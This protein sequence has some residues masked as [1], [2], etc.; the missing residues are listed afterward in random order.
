MDKNGFLL[1]P[2]FI[3]STGV[4][5][6]EKKEPVSPQGNTEQKIATRIFRNF[7]KWRDNRNMSFA[8]FRGRTCLEFWDDC[9][10]R[11]NNYK[12]KP[13]WKDDWQANISDITTHAKLM[14]IVAQSTVNRYKPVFSP[15][16]GR[17]FVSELRSQILQDIYDF[18]E[19]GSGSGT[20]NG[21]L[22][23]LLITLNTAKF[24]TTIGFEG[25]KKTSLYE[26][27]DS[28]II[29]LED[30]YPSDM[31]KFANDQVRCIWRSIISEDE[32]DENFSAWH[33]YDKVAIRVKAGDSQ[34]TTFFNISN[35]IQDKQI[36]LLRYFDKLNDEFYITA[37]GVLITK[38]DST[39]SARRKD[40]ELGFWGTLFEPY[41]QFTFGRSLPDLMKDNQDGID[42]LFNAMYDKELLAVMRPMMVGGVN[43]I[44]DDYNY[45]GRMV[46]VND[47]TQVKEYP[48]APPDLNSFRILK[49]L[50]DRQHFV[51][52]DQVSQG[53]SMGKKTATEVERA[54]EAAKRLSSILGTFVKHGLVQKARLRTGIILQYLIKSPKFRQ[55]VSENVK[56]FE[57]GKAGARTIRIKPKG[58]LAPT[59]GMGFSPRLA[60]EVGIMRGGARGNE[61]IE[62]TP[63]QIADFEYKIDVKAPSSIEMSPALKRAFDI[64]FSQT[65]FARPDV[66][67]QNAVAKDYAEAMGKDYEE[68]RVKEGEQPI[69]PEEGAG[70]APPQVPSLQGMLP[71]TQGIQ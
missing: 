67:D 32:F 63:E 71:Q 10:Q 60:A 26:G 18:T 59:T 54:Q 38:P 24:G 37:N 62:M 53:V 58:Q 61:I 22:D 55:F 56:L 27:I 66:Y 15:R 20:R 50:Q 4:Q 35:E 48:L 43:Q 28:Q 11:F 3:M 33:Q 57:T 45:P 47:V 64:Q 23:N 17:D 52:V 41:G 1:K 49:E 7:L 30:Y 46:N 9:E 14:A 5:E 65:A 34:P 25:Y 42:F 68:V 69:M 29:P 13:D 8:Y 16:F 6:E 70:G 2:F 31:T 39:L 36:E 19:S 44:V 51:A 40:K 21:E 12:V